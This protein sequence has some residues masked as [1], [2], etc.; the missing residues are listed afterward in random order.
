MDLAMMQVTTNVPLNLGDIQSYNG[1]Y[2][3][4]EARLTRFL[5]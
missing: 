3:G 5:A 4:A 1:I 2:Q